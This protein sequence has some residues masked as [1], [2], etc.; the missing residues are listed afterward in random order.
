M[1]LI[2]EA[3]IHVDAPPE[4][5][6]DVLAEIAGWKAW[7]PGVRWAVLE[8][9]LGP[10]G[11]V[12]IRPQRGRQTA[13]HIVAADAPRMLA[14]GLTFGPV[15]GLRCAWTLVPDGTGTRV[16]QTIAIG[17][18]LRRRLVA[19]TAARMHADAPALLAALDH[20]TTSP[21]VAP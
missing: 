3:Q 19:G 13:Y 21:G 20:A 4:R 17:G 11:Y 6:W 5:V 12:T 18:P 15:A 16:T 14:L 7:M 2:G 10:G 8:R 9:G 1:E